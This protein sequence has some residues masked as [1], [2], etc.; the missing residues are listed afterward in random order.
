MSLRRSNAALALAL[1]AWMLFPGAAC[2]A[3][4]TVSSFAGPDIDT[5][6]HIKG[7]TSSVETTPD[8]VRI[9]AAAPV[10]LFRPVDLGHPVDVIVLHTVSAA[11]VQGLLLWHARGTADDRIV[12]LPFAIEPSGNLPTRFAITVHNYPGWD[13]S[14]DAIG[15]QFSAGSDVLLTDVGFHGYSTGERWWNAVLSLGTFDTF[16]R[17]GINFLWG[18]LLAFDPD[19]RATLFNGAPPIA[20]SVNRV[21]LPAIGL[22][23]LT[24]GVLGLWVYPARR[25]RMLRIG[26]GITATAWLLFDL[27]MG[28]EILSYAQ[29]DLTSYVTKPQGERQLRGM[30]DFHDTMEIFLS[31]T[32]G[33]ERI[34]FLSNDD[35]LLNSS[36][37]YEAYPRWVALPGESQE[38]VDTW[39]VFYR[40][41]AAI[42]DQ[43]RLTVGGVPVSP[44]GGRLLTTLNA[45]ASV[46]T[47]AP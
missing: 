41:D 20:W 22:S 6:W 21:L 40:T 24:L 25:T 1:G 23:L 43:G 39:L 34:G 35:L 19:T 28:A 4:A 36:A 16:T 12:Q 11:P 8:G 38:G 13:R 2:A 29:R 47:T 3:W 10:T 33:K 30:A 32:K 18:P 42:D 27:R 15:L 17:H 37:V 5:A 44:P 26:L 31:M 45:H 14:A 46:F 7:P 9:R